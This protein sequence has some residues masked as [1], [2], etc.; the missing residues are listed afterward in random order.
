MTLATI[1]LG[2]NLLVGQ[3]NLPPSTNTN[4]LVIGQSQ[5]FKQVEPK[6]DDKKAIEVTKKETP[7]VEEPKVTVPKAEVY[8]VQSGD[9]LELIATKYN[10]TWQRL[11]NKNTQLPDPNILSVGQEIT[12]PLPDEVLEERI[13][14]QPVVVAP[15]QS[16]ASG[17]VAYR[18]APRP[19]TSSGNTY[20]YGWCTWWVKEKRPDIPN[21]WGNA[22]YGWISSA[23]AAGYS[24]GSIPRAGA[25]G[26]QSGHVA[27]IE[28]V[29]SD[30]SV[31][32]SEMG[33]NYT[34]GVKN[35]RSASAASFQY[36]Y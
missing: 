18:Q 19:A 4:M 35:Y 27:Y 30:G 12:I 5:Q 7:K 20:S 32:V 13:P 26:V 2:L 1:G 21:R 34:Q 36:I 25:I 16:T 11:F 10:V 23:R 3:P 14:P 17:Q 28:S 31:N 9:Y 24:T 6:K 15:T 22:G 8:V 33:W 29:N